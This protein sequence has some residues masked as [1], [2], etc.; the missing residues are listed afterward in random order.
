MTQFYR[1]LAQPLT[2]Q[3]VSLLAATSPPL[4]AAWLLTMLSLPILRWTVGDHVLPWGVYASVV[5]LAVAVV[6]LLGR[7]WGWWA[8]V[9]VALV[10][11]A[12]AWAVEW[13]G[14]STGM[15]FGA[16][17]Y[18]AALQPQLGGVPLLIPLAWLMMLPT[19]WAV[20]YAITGRQRGG[21][22]SLVS[23]LAFTAWDFF[24]D[25][26]MVG[27]G[28]WIWE[29][30]GGYFGIPWLNF[31]GWLLSAALLTLLARPPAPPVTPLLLVYT[32]TW[33]LQTI[34]QLL[35]WQMPG[36]ALSG[37]VTMGIFVVLAWRGLARA[38]K[39]AVSLADSDWGASPPAAVRDPAR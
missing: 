17:T 4:V 35:F 29:P 27:W 8:T 2:S 24:L 21:W 32:I 31:A 3:F 12:G 11:L 23:A 14:S 39:P 33:L 6:E 9:Q 36:P 37:F 26:Q 25:P 15:P 34:G 7:A 16:Y 38:T 10:V 18:T 1:N 28:F 20:A 13:I 19:A 5:I 22:F 30:P